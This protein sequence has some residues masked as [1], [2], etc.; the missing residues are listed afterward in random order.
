MVVLITGTNRGLGLELAKEGLRRGHTIVA[1][2]RTPG[3]DLPS[4]KE[5]YGDAIELQP[6]DVADDASVRAAF[7]E[8][9]RRHAAI[10]GIINNA[11]VL[12]E[13]K[14]FTGDPIVDLDLDQFIETFD[15][16]TFGPVRVLKA[17]MPL[18][19]KG[20]DRFIVNVTT[21]GA[22][23]VTGGSHYIAYSAS[24]IALNLY[25]QKIRNYLSAH[26]KGKNVRVY[27]IHPGRMFTIMGVENAQIQAS[28]PA[29][30]IWDILE[31]KTPVSLEIPFINYKGEEM[32][33]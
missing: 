17:F 26:D 3:P 23:L 24:K 5:D 19:Y 25:T 12:Y 13:T 9:G 18:V 11:A 10:D 28:E 7:Q 8:V 20:A 30:G 1:T 33:R 2:F 29:G 6:M 14:K 16:N 21:E 15:I 4:L 32:P 31:R 27:M 22:R